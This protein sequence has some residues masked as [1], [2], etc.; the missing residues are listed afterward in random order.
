MAAVD[1]TQVDSQLTVEQHPCPNTREAHE[2]DGS[3]ED[4]PY[5]SA[6]SNSNSV[7]AAAASRILESSVTVPVRNGARHQSVPM[8]MTN[9]SATTTAAALTSPPGSGAGA[10][11]VPPSAT[12]PKSAPFPSPPAVGYTSTTISRAGSS[13]AAGSGAGAVAATPIAGATKPHSSTTIAAASSDSSRGSGTG[14][15]ST[16]SISAAASKF[17]YAT[18]RPYADDD[19]DNTFTYSIEE[20]A[21]TFTPVYTCPIISRGE[22]V[23]SPPN[24]AAASKPT[25]APSPSVSGSKG[26]K[27]RK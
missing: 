4:E 21:S 20:A 7:Y 9:T 3:V 13:S 27:K 6:I 10:V 24:T 25:S 18:S 12:V 2:Q 1:D 22:G 23:M 11:M 19:Y 26:H 5:S 14:A 16:T 15:G 17:P 8:E